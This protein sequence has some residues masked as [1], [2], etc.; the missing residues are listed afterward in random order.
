MP[1]SIRARIGGLQTHKHAVEVGLP[2]SRLAVNLAGVAKSETARG[3]VL[4]LSSTL[5]PT[6]ALDVRLEVLAA[7]PRAIGHTS[8]LELSL[9]AAE[10]PARV[11]LLEGGALAPGASG[12][13]Q[14]RLARPLGPARCHRFG[15][16]IPSPRLPA[17]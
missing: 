10:V 2:G 9:G 17:G 15:V 3:D 11:V 13:A 4:A 12:W 5:Q 1:R 16:R 7:A 8:E 6:T 14:L